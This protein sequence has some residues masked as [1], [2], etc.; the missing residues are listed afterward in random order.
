MST[1]SMYQSSLRREREKAVRQQREINGIADKIAKKNIDLN[2]AKTASRIKSLT[3]DIERLQKQHSRSSNNL[4]ATNKKVT[5]LSSKV[6]K[7]E[8]KEQRDIARRQQREEKKRDQAQKALDMR[9][10]NTDAHVVDLAGRLSQVERA[11]LDQVR[12]AVV[13]DGT[14]REFDIFLSHT[15]KDREDTDKLCEDLVACGLSVWYDGAQLKLG[16]S[17]TRQIDIGLTSSR[18]GVIFITQ[19]FLEG[20]YWTEL[21]M[22]A[23]ISSRKRVIPILHGVA[24]GELAQYSA[25]LNDLV[26]L[27]TDT[28][29]FDEIAEEIAQTLT[30]AASVVS[31]RV[32]N[33]DINLHR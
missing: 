18:A 30:D 4:T 26:G 27:S 24:H 19:A 5:D 7:A 14:D 22:G 28:H 3:N 23:L 29:E 13:S 12:A 21:E 31:N 10:A 16:E 17:L 15:Y 11:L 9:V 25:L 8:E 32:D 6:A 20:R 33:N 1:L 2:R